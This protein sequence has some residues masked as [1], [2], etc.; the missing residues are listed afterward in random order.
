MGG[1]RGDPKQVRQVWQGT[2]VGLNIK[3]YFFLRAPPPSDAS[4][5]LADSAQSSPSDYVS[6]DALV[7]ASSPPCSSKSLQ[8]D[9]E[10]QDQQVRTSQFQEQ[11]DDVT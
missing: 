10:L 3:Q 7:H 4:T 2:F 11:L 8:T 9:E 5:R 1:A 6:H